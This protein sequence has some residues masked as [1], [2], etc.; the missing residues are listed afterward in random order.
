MS[1]QTW[2]A[3]ALDE[4]EKGRGLV[5]PNPV[6]GAVIVKDGRE[7]GRGHHARFGGPHAEVAA[8]AVAG[9]EARGAT[10]F[11]T[12]EPCCHH[13][14]TPP[15]TD[16]IL[17]AG[18]AKVVVSARDPFP[19]VNGGGLDRLRAAGVTVE[20]G[21]LGDRAARQNAPFFKRV[22]T[23]HPYVIA[24]WAM[25]LDGKVAAATGDSRWISGEASRAEVH[26]VR[27]RMDAILV[28]IGTALA[29]DP[30]L[31]VRPPGPRT[32][33]RVILDGEARIPVESRLVSTSRSVPVLVAVTGRAAADRCRALTDAGCE[34]LSL[35]SESS[36]IPVV[37]LLSKLGERGMTNILVEGGGRILGAFLDAGQI[38]EVDAFLAPML[39]G[40][41]HAS[42][43][44]RGRGV[45]RMPDSTRL[46]GVSYSQV[47]PDLR[48]RGWLDQPWR[49]RL[50]DLVQSPGDD[51]S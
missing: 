51:R 23:G 12:L 2:M 28:G 14:K 6:V 30:Q 40:G 11:V 48:V 22:Y 39:E 46:E 36:R 15:C 41:D 17:E 5:E 37:P 10:L 38:D 19:R 16:A 4:A 32:P 29:D 31:T 34:V 43:A 27:G 13:G 25:T 20:L 26:R 7:V 24:K 47:G 8:L 9:Q 49:A 44:I 33:L 50:K 45:L 3:I 42:T 35:P 1:D 21:L 18:I